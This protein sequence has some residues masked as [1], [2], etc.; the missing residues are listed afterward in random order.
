MK[1]LIQQLVLIPKHADQESNVITR[2]TLNMAIGMGVLSVFFVTG[3]FLFA[4]ELAQ[5]ATWFAGVF[6]ITS[7]GIIALVRNK[8]LQT[9]GTLLIGVMWLAVT[10]GAITA[11]GIAAPIFIGYIVVIAAGGLLTNKKISSSISALCIISGIL[12]VTAEQNGW[13]AAPAQYTSIARLSIYLFFIIIAIMLQNINAKNIQDLIKQTTNS[14]KQ[15]RA[16]LE[17]IPTTT[18]INTIDEKALTE[19]VSPQVEKL[20]GYPREMFTTDPEFWKKIL[21][22]DD[23]QRVM[24][25]SS[26]GTLTGEPFNLEYRLITKDQRVIWVKDEANLVKDANGIPQYWLGVWTDIT[27]RKQAEDEQADLIGTMTKRNIQLQTAAEVSRAASSIL[28]LNALLPNVVE[29][30]CNHFDYYYVGVFLI[31]ETNEWAVLS[32]ASSEAGREMLK[33]GHRLKIEDSSMIGW[34]IRNKQARIALDVGEDAVRFKNPSLPLTRSEIALPLITHRAV[35][36]AMTIQ[37]S[38]PAAF[39]RLDIATLQTMADQMAIVIENARLFTERSQL[40]SELE[41]RNSELEQFTYTVSHDLRSPLVTIRGFL[42]YLQQDAISGD[43]DRFNKDMN[44][45]ANAVDKMQALL[46]DLLELSRIGRVINPS[47]ELPFETIIQETVELLHGPL[48]KNRIKLV[49][50]ETFP[51]VYGDHARLVEALQNLISNSAKFMGSQEQPTIVIG[52]SGIDGDGK[53]VF[54]VRDNGIG[55][56]SQYHERIF[57]LFNRLDPSIDGTGIGL[58]LV[59]RIIETHGGRIWLN[60]KIGEGTTFYFTLPQG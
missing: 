36:G 7:I 8:Y 59:K 39:S 51:R 1:K 10:L 41:A 27:T 4:P 40:I 6:S 44:R 46:N 31:D 15:Y 12:I 43:M 29:L 60:S 45:V 50:Q 5:R 14:E 52:T 30:I 17:N 53:P 34:S 23:H 20:L 55:I 13:L 35:I 25:S 2:L 9:A 19:Y 28:D 24:A 3:A 58:T 47:E 26:A 33:S 49:S 38:L 11:G 42:G 32:A 57:G 21:H 54:F 22:P 48:E 37:S 18:Y 16:L 56:D